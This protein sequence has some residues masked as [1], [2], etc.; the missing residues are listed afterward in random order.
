MN[1]PV[2]IEFECILL[3]VQLLK[4]GQKV[5]EAVS[6]TSLGSLKL[7]KHERLAIET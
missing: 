4:K 3:S 5:G 2:W 7:M 6:H 1:I